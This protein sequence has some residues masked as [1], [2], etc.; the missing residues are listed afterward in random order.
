MRVSDLLALLSRVDP[1]MEVLAHAQHGDCRFQFFDIES[2]DV[3]R[4]L[5]SRDEA[6]MPQAVLD[7]EAG[8]PLALLTLTSEF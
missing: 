4:A 6:G 3:A 1:A 2:V 7:D 5:R 8:R